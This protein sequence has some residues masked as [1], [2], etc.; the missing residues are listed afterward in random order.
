MP[1]GHSPLTQ[2][3]QRLAE[4]SD[5]ERAAML[6]AWDQEVPM[7]PAGAEWRAQQ[8]ASIERLAHERFVDDEVGALLDAAV[9][10]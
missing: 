6:L 3:R 1:A 5:L 9:P 4:V 10:E 2:L 8:R 7:P